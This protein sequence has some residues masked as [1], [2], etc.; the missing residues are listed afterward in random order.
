MATGMGTRT[1]IRTMMVMGARMGSERRARAREEGRLMRGAGVCVRTGGASSTNDRIRT[2]SRGAG[3]STRPIC[4]DH[5]GE[6]ARIRV[7]RGAGVCG[8]TMGACG[9][10][11]SGFRLGLRWRSGWSQ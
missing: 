11:T 5:G 8:E 6:L 4:D 1:R 3:L 10:Q 9:G 7:Q 2:G